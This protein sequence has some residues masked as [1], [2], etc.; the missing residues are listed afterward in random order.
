MGR[1]ME[2]VRHKKGRG[3]AVKG[4][5][6]RRKGKGTEWK[7]KGR[8]GD[9]EGKEGRQEG[10]TW[11]GGR[12]RKGEKEGCLTVTCRASALMLGLQYVL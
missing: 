10:R 12:K 5:Q 8:V 1:G 7:G 3:K 6:W 4:G 9:G 2:D 11:E